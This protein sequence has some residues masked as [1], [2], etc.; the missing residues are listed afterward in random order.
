MQALAA[1]ALLAG[2]FLS[3]YT[4][5]SGS[6][7]PIGSTDKLKDDVS[8]LCKVAVFLG[9]A[10]DARTVQ[11]ALQHLLDVVVSRIDEIWCAPTSK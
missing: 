11:N 4:A 10:D 2:P 8:E 1:T 7:Y 6:F 3:Y 9:R 5:S